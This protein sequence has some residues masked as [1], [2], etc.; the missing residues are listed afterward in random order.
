[1]NGKMVAIGIGIVALV[2][3]GLAFK[4]TLEVA[5]ITDRPNETSSPITKATP[6]AWPRA[7]WEYKIS[8]HVG[9]PTQNLSRGTTTLDREF[10]R[11]DLQYNLEAQEEFRKLLAVDGAD[12]WELVGVVPQMSDG[13]VRSHLL[14]FKRPAKFEKATIVQLHQDLGLPV[15][16]FPSE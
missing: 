12:G 2:V 4:A 7:G 13:Q 11:S 10:A 6:S 5:S 15:P 16:L 14:I 9:H 3:A 8:E 1:M